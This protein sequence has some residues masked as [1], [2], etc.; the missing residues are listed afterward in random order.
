MLP[1]F[2]PTGVYKGNKIKQLLHTVLVKVHVIR[3]KYP[4]QMN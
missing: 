2:L 3:V 1:N 4:L